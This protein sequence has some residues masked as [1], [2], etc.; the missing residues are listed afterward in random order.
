M[1]ATFGQHPTGGAVGKDL[2]GLHREHELI[3][4]AGVSV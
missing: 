2:V 3:K 1:P 4:V